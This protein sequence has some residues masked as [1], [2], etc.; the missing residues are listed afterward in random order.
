MAR[1]ED[2]HWLLD[3]KEDRAVIYLAAAPRPIHWHER[4]KIN[5]RVDQAMVE[6]VPARESWRASPGAHARIDCDPEWLFRNLLAVPAERSSACE[7][8]TSQMFEEEK[9]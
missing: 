5:A 3:P 2:V 7:V 4:W 9:S 8:L 6:R 1:T